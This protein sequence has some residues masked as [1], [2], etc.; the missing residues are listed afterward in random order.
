M[1]GENAEGLNHDVEA[2]KSLCATPTPRSDRC[3]GGI[4]DRGI[5]WHGRLRGRLRIPLESGTDLQ[6]AADAAALAAVQDLIP[7][8]DGDQDLAQARATAR[9]F[10]QSNLEKQYGTVN[11]VEGKKKKKKKKKTYCCTPSSI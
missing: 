6:R 10:A 11:E 7:S 8:D 3:F 9:T 4:Y 1:S 5:R 2:K